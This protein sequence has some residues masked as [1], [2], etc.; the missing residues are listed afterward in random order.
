MCSIKLKTATILK[1]AIFGETILNQEYGKNTSASLHKAAIL[2]HCK[3]KINKIFLENNDAKIGDTNLDKA[4]KMS[5]DM[6]NTECD[7]KNNV[8]YFVS[9]GISIGTS[10][11]GTWPKGTSL[12]EP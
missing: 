3:D 12:K 4:A 7:T 9:W 8:E 2:Q 6:N 11:K 10:T 5:P 1:K